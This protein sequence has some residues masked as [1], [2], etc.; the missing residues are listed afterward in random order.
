M[1]N[2]CG[3][4]TQ[5][6]LEEFEQMTAISTGP[7]SFHGGECGMSFGFFRNSEMNQTKGIPKPRFVGP[8]GMCSW[9]PAR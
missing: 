2:F 4:C 5:I 1:T 3:K 7:E 6:E 9:R 8:I